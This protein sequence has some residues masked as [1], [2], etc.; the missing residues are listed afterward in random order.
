VSEGAVTGERLELATAVGSM[1]RTSTGAPVT[2]LARRYRVEG[3]RLRYELDMELESVALTR[4]L[5]AILQKVAVNP[6]PPSER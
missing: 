3:D 5:E 1:G 2:A 4:H 6:R